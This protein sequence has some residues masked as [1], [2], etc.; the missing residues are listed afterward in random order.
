M[1]RSTAIVLLSLGAG[2]V[3]FY[4][5]RD[6][7]RTSEA[8]VFRTVQDCVLGQSLAEA[9]CREEY[10]QALAEHERT[11]PR[12]TNR[13]ECEAE[14]GANACEQRATGTSSGSV[15]MPLLAGYMIGHATAGRSAIS[16]Q[17]LYPPR[18]GANTCPPDASG[19]Q[20]ASCPPSGSSS[21]GGS[22]SGSSYRTGHGT[23]IW[24]GR[25]GSGTSTGLSTVRTTSPSRTTTS[26]PRTVA[27]P[28]PSRPNTVSRNGFGQTSRSFSFSSRSSGT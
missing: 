8:Y 12:Y 21:S 16:S 14:F 13:A 5:F 11:A 15:F 17:P 26:V 24:V 2:A 23:Y 7:G 20:P 22:S 19:V 6:P 25:G 27:S 28:P 18:P 3:A 9:A 1:K 10:R 4:A